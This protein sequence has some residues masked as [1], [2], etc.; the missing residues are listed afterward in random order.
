MPFKKNDPK[1]RMA[2]LKGGMKT[3]ERLKADPEYYQNLG[4]IGGNKLMAQK[5]KQYFAEI[6]KLPRRKKTEL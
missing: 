2:G 6:S 1:T 5:G 3:K 4:I